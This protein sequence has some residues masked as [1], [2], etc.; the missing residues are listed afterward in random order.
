M[1]PDGPTHHGAFDIAALK[2]IPN[3]I[4]MA[5]SSRDELYKML[6]TGFKLG[7]PCAVRYPRTEG[8]GELDGITLDDTVELGK[9]RIL[10]EGAKTVLLCFGAFSQDYLEY[11]KT[12]GYTLV[13]MRFIKPWDEALV[14]EL[15]KTHERI[16]TVEDGVVKGGIGEEIASFVQRERGDR[17]IKV[18]NLGLPDRYIMEGTRK[19]I[20]HD[21]K[22]DVSGLDETLAAFLKE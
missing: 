22:L 10:C 16:I 12:K 4:I 5:P 21:L 1:G 9:G 15:M 6:N 3:L 11:A 8:A 17:Q 13:D 14:K 19:E 2:A 18:L 7:K 20:M